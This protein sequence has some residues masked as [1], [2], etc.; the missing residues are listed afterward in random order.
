MSTTQIQASVLHGVK[1]LRVVSIPKQDIK[2]Y[3]RTT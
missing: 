3:S 2:V 1:D